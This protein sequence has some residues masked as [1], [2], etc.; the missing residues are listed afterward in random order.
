MKRGSIQCSQNFRF[1]RLIKPWDFSSLL[2]LQFNI[3]STYNSCK[4]CFIQVPLRN[5]WK[6]C[7]TENT[8]DSLRSRSVSSNG[9]RRSASSAFSVSGSNL[10]SSDN[11]QIS[12]V[13]PIAR[14]LF[15]GS[16]PDHDSAG[17]GTYP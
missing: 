4:W 5:S 7:S 12:S 16:Y 2:Q 17:N 13:S 6:A 1:F 9:L 10:K 14:S 8:P 11:H 15:S 3:Y